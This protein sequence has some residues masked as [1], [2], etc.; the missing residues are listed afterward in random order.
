MTICEA[1][2]VHVLPLRR[3]KETVPLLG[4][5]LAVSLPV[6]EKGLLT[7]AEE[8]ADMVRAVGVFASTS[9][10]AL[11]NNNPKIASTTATTITILFPANTPL[12]LERSAYTR[13]TRP[14]LATTAFYSLLSFSLQNR[15]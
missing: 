5:P 7:G 15:V 4:A 9:G 8:G 10:V 2:V 6:I 12:H 13:A 14:Y 11:H 1:R 3:C